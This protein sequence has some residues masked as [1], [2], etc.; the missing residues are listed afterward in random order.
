MK[1]CK[2]VWSEGA[3]SYPNR[4]LG[5]SIAN[6]PSI[7]RETRSTTSPSRLTGMYNRFNRF[8]ENSYNCLI[9]EGSSLT[10]YSLVPRPICG[11]G[12]VWEQG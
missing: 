1:N 4:S 8:N 6:V 2:W 3:W 5:T 9:E 7:Y 10:D 11:R 12:S